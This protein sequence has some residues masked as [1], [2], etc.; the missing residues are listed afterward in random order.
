VVRLVLFRV[1]RRVLEVQ[2]RGHL[3]GKSCVEGDN[4]LQVPCSI[5][6]LGRLLAA[7]VLSCQRLL[8]LSEFSV[9]NLLVKD[10]DSREVLAQ[11]R[12]QMVQNMARRSKLLASDCSWSQF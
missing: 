3:P 10:E 6:Y 12:Y 9:W 2:V 7:S 5:N 1:H 11:S 4:L 8:S